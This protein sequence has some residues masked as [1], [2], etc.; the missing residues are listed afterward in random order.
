[1]HSP[2]LKSVVLCVACVMHGKL[3]AST[4]EH[5]RGVSDGLAGRG[6][7][8]NPGNSHIKL[9]S[10]TKTRIQKAIET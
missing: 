6:G 2:A 1:M 8:A 7:D 10:T 4:G 3:Y 5:E 9:D